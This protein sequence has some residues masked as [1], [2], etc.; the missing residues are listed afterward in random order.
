MSG[1]TGKGKLTFE[2]FM[3]L[4]NMDLAYSK[5]VEVVLFLSLKK[6]TKLPP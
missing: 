2:L 4:S 1:P 6:V 5:S 3:T